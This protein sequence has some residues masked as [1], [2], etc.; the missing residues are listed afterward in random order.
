MAQTIEQKYAS[1]RHPLIEELKLAQV[2]FRHRI[3]SGGTSVNGVANNQFIGAATIRARVNI[4]SP[5][6][7][8]RQLLPRRIVTDFFE[9]LHRCNPGNAFHHLL[10]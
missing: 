4:L 9:Q 8:S 7:P 10:N 3:H 5:E 1:F 6:L 2:R